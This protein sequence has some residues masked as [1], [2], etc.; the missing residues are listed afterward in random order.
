VWEKDGT[1]LTVQS[2]HRHQANEAIFRRLGFEPAPEPKLDRKGRAAAKAKGKTRAKAK[3]NT[4][5]QSGLHSRLLFDRVRT[6]S[7]IRTSQRACER[8]ARG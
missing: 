7:P 5:Y 6:P 4:W 3:N 1:G 2:H 8:G